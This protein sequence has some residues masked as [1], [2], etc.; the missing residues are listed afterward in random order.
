MTFDKH[1]KSLEERDVVHGSRQIFLEE[2]EFG[3][4]HE[5]W[6]DIE[7][8]GQREHCCGTTLVALPGLSLSASKQKSQGN[9]KISMC[10]L[11]T[12]VHMGGRM[13]LS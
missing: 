3:S 6:F 1:C 4:N 7:G 2:V 13:S 10:L 12:Q 9:P 11:M 8:K 5:H